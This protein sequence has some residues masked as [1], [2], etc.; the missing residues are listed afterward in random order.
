MILGIPPACYK[1]R[2]YRSRVVREPRAVLPDLGVQ[3]P[4]D[5][6]VR[7]HDSNAGLRYLV[8]PRRPEGT[9][10]WTEQEL[11]QLVTRDS[12][13]GTGVARDPPQILAAR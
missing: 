3:L 2:E 13:I 10:G 11:A 4:E 9:E 7:V 12:M 1:S 8:I 5:I 6:E